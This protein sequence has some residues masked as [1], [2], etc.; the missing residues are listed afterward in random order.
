MNALEGPG[1]SAPGAPAAQDGTT[2][3][4]LPSLASAWGGGGSSFLPANFFTPNPIQQFVSTPN[5]TINN[6]AAQGHIFF[7][8]SANTAVTPMVVGST[9]QT[10]GNGGGSYPILNDV[11]GFLL[12]GLRNYS[13]AISCY[14]TSGNAMALN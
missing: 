1:A 2:S 9:V 10:V 14:Y 3:M 13:M 12:F 7:P 5:G 11:L 4:T 8:G 6:T